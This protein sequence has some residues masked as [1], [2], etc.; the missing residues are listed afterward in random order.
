LLIASIGWRSGSTLPQRIMMTDPS[1]LI[2]DE[3]FDPIL[4]VNPFTNAGAAL[5]AHW[6]HADAWSI[7]ASRAT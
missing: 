2:W 7:D 6:P 1:I 4:V 5:D 3:P